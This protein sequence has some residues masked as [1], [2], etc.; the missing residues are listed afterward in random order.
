VFEG[1]AKRGS[2][3]QRS[4]SCKSTSLPFLSYYLNW[5]PTSLMLERSRK[6]T[7]GGWTNSNYSKMLQCKYICES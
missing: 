6:D 4:S 3:K 2:L 1:I 7:N 5:L